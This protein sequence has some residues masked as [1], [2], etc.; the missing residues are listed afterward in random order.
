MAAQPPGGEGRLPPPV[1]SSHAPGRAATPP[2]IPE[3]TS[4]VA[5]DDPASS[6]S[7]GDDAAAVDVD[8]GEATKPVEAPDAASAVEYLAELAAREAEATSDAG[9]ESL[10]DLHVRLA[11]FQLD[12][13]QD[14]AAAE[15]HLEQA[16]DHPLATRLRFGRALSSGDKDVLEQVTTELAEAGRGAFLDDDGDVLA[17]RDASEAWLYRFAEPGRAAEMARLGLDKCKTGDGAGANPVADD[18]RYVR[19]VALAAAERWSELADELSAPGN[20][21]HDVAS[22]LAALEASHVLE[23][24]VGDAAGAAEVVR[25]QF[26]GLSAARDS[27]ADTGVPATVELSLIDRALE[28]IALGAEGLDEKRLLDRR[29]DLLAASESSV[30]EAAATRL[31]L[32]QH[33]ARAGDQAGAIDLLAELGNPGLSEGPDSAWG[34]R[35]AARIR[36]HLFAATGAWADVAMALAALAKRDDAGAAAGAYLRRAAEVFD[37]RL[38]DGERALELWNELLVDSSDSQASRAVERRQIGGDPDVLMAHFE[39]VG[40]NTTAAARAFAKRRAAAVAEARAGDVAS[41]IALRQ[42]SI[43]GVDRAADLEDA[44]RLQRLAGDREALARG[45]IELAG[46]VKKPRIASALKCAAGAVEL[47]R[48]QTAEAERAFEAASMAGGRDIVSRAAL[49]LL[50]RKSD[51]HEDLARVLSDLAPLLKHEQNRLGALRE[52]GRVMAIQLDN[53]KGALKH[54]EGA[55]EIEPTDPDTLV[56][57]GELYGKVSNWPKAVELRERAVDVLEA[58]EARVRLLLEIGGIH[59]EHRRDEQAAQRAYEQAL[60]LDDSCAAAMDA[61]A[62]L[63]Q[64]NDRFEDLLAVLRRREPLASDPAEK[65]EMR[66]R[67]ARAAEKVG[68]SDAVI[69]SARQVLSS[70]PDQAEA[71]EILHR[72]GTDAKRYEDIAEAFRAAPRNV[73]NLRIIADACEQTGDWR[74]VADAI[75]AQVEFATSDA[76]RGK[77]AADAAAIHEAKLNAPGPAIEMYQKS[78]SYD[79]S[80]K[81]AQEA[82]SRLLEGS[83][84]WPELVAQ[85]ERELGEVPESDT[86]RRVN[87]L[88]RLGTLQRDQLNA[89]D[90]AAAAFENALGLDPGNESALASLEPLYEKLGREEDLLRVLEERGAHIDNAGEKVERFARI[91]EVKATRGDIDGAIKAFAAAFDADPANR[92]TF[93]AME[94]LSY[95]HER[96]SDAMS[97]YDQAIAL[98]ESG[99][100]RAYRLGD[101]YARRGQIQLQYLGQPAE[102]ASSYIR[103][104][105]LDPDNDTAL[106]FLESIHS[107]QGDWSGLINAY[108]TRAQLSSDDT[109]RVEALRR[110]A[111]VAGAKLKDPAEAARVYESILTIDPGD[112]ESLDSLERFHERAGDWDKLVGVLRTRLTAAP[113]G[114]AAVAL[115]KRIARICEE[116]LRSEDRAIENYLRILEI[117]PGNKDALEALGRIYESTERWAEF[118]DVT[119]RQIRVTTDRNVKALLYFKCGSVM[120]AKFGKQEDA[121]RYYDAAIK[122]SPSCLPAVHGLR[123]L[124]RRR[125]DWPRVI[126]TLELEVKLWQDDKER[127]GVFAQ[128]GQIYAQQLG[129]PDRALHY[130]ESALAVDPECLPANRAL[131]EQYFEARD[132]ER[133]QPLAQALAQKAM[134]EGD[135]SQRS[136]FYLRRGVVAQHTGD[137]RGAAESTIIALEIKPDNIEALDALG[138]LARDEPD[139]YDFEATYRELDKLYKKRDQSEPF[140]ARV[141]VAQA[142][143]RS[144]EGDL[145]A[146]ESNYRRAL[147]LASQ[148]FTILSALVDLHCSMRRWTHAADAIRSFLDSRP[149]PEH[150][151]RVQALMRLAQI[152]DEGE[153]DPHRAAAALREVLKYDAQ[154]QDAH[155]LLAQQLVLL[156]RFDDARASINK[157]IEIAAAPGA[158]LSPTALARYYYYLGHIKSTGGD[159]RGSVSQYR[160]AAE[161][162]PGYAPP[163]VALAKRAVENGD[164]RGA[165]SLLINAAHAAMEQGG[166]TA[167]VPLQ[168]GLA[169]I[170]LG[171][172]D[173]AAAIEAYRGILAVDPS[174]S[175]D[176]VALAEIYAVDDIERAVLE[177]NRVIERDLR[178]APAYRQLASYYKRQD[179][180]D[181]C[182]RVLS[183][184]EMLGYAEEEDKGALAHARSA[185][186]HQ[187]LR[188]H[189]DEENRARVLLP[190]GA[191]SVLSNVF[192]AVAEEVTGLFPQPPMGENLSPIQTIED[193]TLK[194][195]IA[196][197]SRLFGVEPE[198]YLGQNVPGGMAVLAYP[199]RIV[200]LD[201]GLL[202]E[203][204]ACRRFLLGRA[205]EA[206]RGGY[207]L[208]L[209]LTRRER[210]ELGH[211]LRSMLMPENEQMQPTKEFVRSLPKRAVRIIERFIGRH[212]ESE[213]EEWIDSMIASAN[214]AGLFACD[215]FHAAA[216]MLSRLAGEAM[217]VTQDGALAVGA[218][219]GGEDLVR[220]YLVDEYHQL[221]LQLAAP[222]VPVS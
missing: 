168:R 58:A 60:D 186:T 45:Y 36:Q 120:E 95:K 19:L 34:A 190:K 5:L 144:R 83:E 204:D 216:D 74:G 167:A 193:P 38:D 105:E 145:D 133:A 67:I 108:E 140:Q 85:L 69:E 21:G 59:R 157:C 125:E 195:A 102:A 92:E 12:V 20:G 121:I 192:A 131:F 9:G 62:D 215:D 6:T 44:A 97:L 115:L 55:L 3:Q 173:R 32:A 142:G 64:K 117:A 201:E 202:T 88:I 138:D 7:V 183:I 90:E 176:R 136:T 149:A 110:A 150:E 8:F 17:L 109:K 191:R 99:N 179:A 220:F 126:Q 79:P 221:R 111:R 181:Q 208:L 164:Q 217:A 196:D 29:L 26:E 177:L 33:T 93:T 54:L 170:L 154:H 57:L 218:I 219:A 127:A 103:V 184:M 18:L 4:P 152:Y 81:D 52:L 171:S 122:T 73:E 112:K 104:V 43:I 169:R 114:D 48:G 162:D 206:I 174:E 165:E 187:P 40:H 189:L 210:L 96:W 61:L 87:M 197:T 107:Q 213:P 94:R 198:V 78:L 84:R 56:A 141:L 156:G 91:A 31:L 66:M 185:Q 182:V 30:V 42:Q 180:V 188:G 77:L 113:A 159:L 153:M 41:A 49:A 160:R 163:A 155:Y 63:H 128:I 178:H 119:R 28:L 13:M 161:Y 10:A 139:A 214:R 151:K 148:D 175:A 209:G 129:Q 134:R 207:A 212:D 24:R 123:D 205:Y 143:M 37:A 76:E 27:G 118:I 39:A 137:P 101:L 16:A 50:Y 200:V 47:S 80:S 82:V 72:V 100:S 211:L 22:V 35:L 15:K 98:V 116:G 135:P 124:Y 65:F 25:K 11:L 146:A 89:P 23:D 158:A 14:A 203:S 166:A 199:R 106:K 75:V 2:P 147:E 194:V 132:W 51:R 1:P 46:K 86:A 70:Q 53:P 222:P 130:Y 68:D 71:L 172:G